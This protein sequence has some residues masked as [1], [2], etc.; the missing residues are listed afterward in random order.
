M[1][2]THPNKHPQPS[3]IVISTPDKTSKQ[4][5]P[6]S[7]ITKNSSRS[8]SFAKVPP[9]NP[10]FFSKTSMIQLGYGVWINMTTLVTGL[11]IGFTAIALP[12]MQQEES[13]IKITLSQAAWIGRY[14]GYGV[15]NLL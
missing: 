5:S 7:W 1:T 11:A 4:T 10:N 12:Q 8:F 15:G 14:G 9:A 2:S 6:I 13:K 3:S